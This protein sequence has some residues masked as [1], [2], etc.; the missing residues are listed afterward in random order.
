MKD[1]VHNWIFTC[2]TLCV[3]KRCGIEGNIVIK[4]SK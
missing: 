3:C 2:G 1:C 4:E